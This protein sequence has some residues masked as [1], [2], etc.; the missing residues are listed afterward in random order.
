[1]R[2]DATGPS[3]PPLLGAIAREP[4][5]DDD[6]DGPAVVDGSAQLCL[7]AFCLSSC[8]RRPVPYAALGRW[9]HGWG[10]AGRATDVVHVWM[11]T[12]HYVRSHGMHDEFLACVGARGTD[13]RPPPPDCGPLVCTAWDDACGA[14]CRHPVFSPW[15]LCRYH[16]SRKVED[17]YAGAD[18]DVDLP[19][20]RDRDTT[21]AVS[22]AVFAALTH[23]GLDADLRVVDRPGR[24]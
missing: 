24:P 16:A 13:G 1:V 4:L 10:D 12:T 3:A 2:Y 20:T 17:R 7:L 8:L 5:F 23:M 9:L 15:V 14:Y 6:D 19:P 18:Y 11:R 21:V 22:R